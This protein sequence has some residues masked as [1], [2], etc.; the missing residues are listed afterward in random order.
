MALAIL[1]YG[2]SEQATVYIHY[3]LVPG[4]WL[5]RRNLHCI[6][7]LVWKG[8]GTGALCTVAVH[9]QILR[10]PNYYFWCGLNS[11]SQGFIVVEFFVVVVVIL[12]VYLLL[13]QVMLKCL[14]LECQN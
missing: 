5:L 2:V 1:I 4:R 9:K 8:P 12:Y 3:T 7:E 13:F 10:V 11:S 14:S 6:G